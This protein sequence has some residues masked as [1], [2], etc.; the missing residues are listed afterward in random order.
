MNGFKES[1]MK[2]IDKIET[3]E[4]V[5]EDFGHMNVVNRF[6]GLKSLTLI[7]CGIAH[8]EVFLCSCRD[9][10]MPPNL[11]ICGSTKMK[12]AKLTVWISVSVSRVYTYPTTP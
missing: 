2:E 4:L 3:I 6:R 9:S 10:K 7:N 11:N 5:L 1:H 8:I 12:S